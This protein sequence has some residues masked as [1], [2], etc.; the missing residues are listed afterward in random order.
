MVNELVQVL[1]IKL[2][3]PLTAFER[4]F[5]ARFSLDAVEAEARSAGLPTEIV[6]PPFAKH[7]RISGTG[8]RASKMRFCSTSE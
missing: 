4:T 5:E 6:R 8:D 7:T 1:E 2:A 3:K